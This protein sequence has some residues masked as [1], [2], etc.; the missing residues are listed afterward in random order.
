MFSVQTISEPVVSQSHHLITIQTA[1]DDENSCVNMTFTI[2]NNVQHND[3][4][5]P[6]L[7]AAS[8][9]LTK[10]HDTIKSEAGRKN[11]ECRVRRLRNV[12]YHEINIH[13]SKL[14]ELLLWLL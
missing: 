13:A 14:K 7:D 2:D 11:V 3:R 5:W 9:K 12:M 6:A 4:T 8:T 10:L 1:T